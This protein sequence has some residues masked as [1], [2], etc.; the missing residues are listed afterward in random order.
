[1]LWSQQAVRRQLV[2]LV[3]ART[4]AATQAYKRAE[5]RIC[6]RRGEETLPGTPAGLRI[7]ENML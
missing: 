1:M 7:G 5:G 2:V 3:A 4:I 6:P